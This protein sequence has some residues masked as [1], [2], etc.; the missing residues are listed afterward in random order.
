[1]D[2]QE[3]INKKIEEATK[4]VN[5]LNIRIASLKSIKSEMEKESKKEEKYAD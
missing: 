2:A 4:K 1:M 5:E 3:V